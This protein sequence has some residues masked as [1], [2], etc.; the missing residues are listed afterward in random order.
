MSIG[1]NVRRLWA[2]KMAKDAIPAGSGIDQ[3][4]H[5]LLDTKA[6]LAGARSATDWTKSAIEAIRNAGDP[7]PWKEADDEVIA[8]ELLRRI[9]ERKT[10]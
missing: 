6:F 3:G 10:A 5:F 9:E 1:P 8:G 2:T 7:N 4:L